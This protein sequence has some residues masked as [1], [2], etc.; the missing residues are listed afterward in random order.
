MESLKI[1]MYFVIIT[2][3]KIISASP[4]S[5]GIVEMV[6]GL[7][8]GGIP[9]G[10]VSGKVG[11][12]YQSPDSGFYF[13]QDNTIQSQSQLRVPSPIVISPNFRAA[14]VE[15][16]KYGPVQIYKLPGVV[17]PGVLGTKY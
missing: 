9:Y 12:N 16:R 5:A 17:A 6:N 2:I 11:I 3:A 1:L 13:R 8:Y 4:D 10:S 7:A 15:A 14:G